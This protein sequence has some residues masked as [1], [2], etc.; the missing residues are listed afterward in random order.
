M[1]LNLV[2][3]KP[4]DKYTILK[5]LIDVRNDGYL[6]GALRRKHPI[7]FTNQIDSLVM[8]INSLKEFLELEQQFFSWGIGW[9][10][11]KFKPLNLKEEYKPYVYGLGYS[12]RTQCLFFVSNYKIQMDNLVY[13]TN[14]VSRNKCLNVHNYINYLNGG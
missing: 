5:E 3:N 14:I 12:Y 4:N 13:E 2:K 7:I 9:Y 6:G 8:P 10:N 1:L 11:N